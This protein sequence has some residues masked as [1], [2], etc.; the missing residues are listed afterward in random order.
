MLLLSLLMVNCAI[1]PFLPIHSLDRLQLNLMKFLPTLADLR[2]AH[3][4]AMHLSGCYTFII[5]LYFYTY[6]VLCLWRVY[7]VVP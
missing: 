1:L 5:L 7:S 2:M 6:C 3:T 4:S